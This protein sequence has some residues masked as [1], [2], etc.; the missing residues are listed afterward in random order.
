ML[1][2]TAPVGLERRWKFPQRT[3]SC[4]HDTPALPLLSPRGLIRQ[5]VKSS[6]LVVSLGVIGALAGAAISHFVHPR[7][8]AAV[9]IQIGQITAT[10][11]SRQYSRAIENPLTAIDR[12][13]LPAFRLGVIKNLGLPSPD[14][15][16]MESK[17]IFDSLNATPETSPDLVHLQ[18]SAYSRQQAEITLRSAFDALAAA[19]RQLYDPAVDNMKRDLEGAS[20]KLAAAQ[21]DYA[22]SYQVMRSSTE[23]GSAA[24]DGTRNIL[25]TNMATQIN[26]Q[27]LQLKQEI[28]LLQQALSPMNTYP[29]RMVEA[30][31]APP[32]PR[33]PS[34]KL[35]IA[36]GA[37]LGLLAGAALA[38]RADFKRP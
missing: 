13:N 19:H 7:W 23:Q 4:M 27:I 6:K 18:V 1:H 29:T 16:A 26:T 11:G 31:Y 37:V 12:F 25:V 10:D 5:I 24:L 35:L 22:R 8:V 20:T 30:P 34:A 15:G 28:A 17:E 21:S 3:P 9:T 32:H 38:L 36:A 14:S 33:S 2:G